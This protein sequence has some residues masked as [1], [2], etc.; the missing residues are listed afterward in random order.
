MLCVLLFNL[1]VNKYGGGERSL[2][3]YLSVLIL[4]TATHSPILLV[5]NDKFSVADH[6]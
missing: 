3:A 5:L 6:A 4:G 2:R 1:F